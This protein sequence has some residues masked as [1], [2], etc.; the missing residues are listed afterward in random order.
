M[1]KEFKDIGL[2][3]MKNSVTGE[4]GY[5]M[6]I[7][8][9]SVERLRDYLVQAARGSDGLPIGS[10]AWNMRRVEK[11]LPWYGVDFS[12]ENFPDEARLG[13]TVSYEKGCFLGQE[14]LARLH[15]RGH[16]NRVLVGLTMDEDDVPENVRSLTAEFEQE[17]NNYDEPGL[18]EK[19]GAVA[20]SLDLS[21]I[22]RPK[23]ELFA[24]ENTSGDDE[25]KKKPVG[26]ITSAAYSPELKKPLLLAYLRYELAGGDAHVQLP[27]G[28]RLR[29]VA[30][31]LS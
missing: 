13:D 9:E 11:G 10:I 12:S 16:V 5:H 14:T 17:I 1:A 4:D 28:R 3:M 2:Y 6:M 7:P 24:I 26:W 20:R 22:F 21:T 29:K 19:A 18:K 25:S 30:L 31:L 15:H 27:D 8:S 23:A